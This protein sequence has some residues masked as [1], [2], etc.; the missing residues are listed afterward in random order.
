[1]PDA[2]GPWI[3]RTSPLLRG[4]VAAAPGGG[5][6]SREVIGPSVASIMPASVLVA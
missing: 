4:F 2:A 3:S 6:V 5:S 1:M